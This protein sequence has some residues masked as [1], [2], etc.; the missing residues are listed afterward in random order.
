MNKI[1]NSG[2]EA[3]KIYK[4]LKAHFNQKSY[5]FNKY[6]ANTKKVVESWN[7]LPCKNLFTY[8]GKKLNLVK[9]K[10]L[11]IANL[12]LDKNYFPVNFD[13]EY[14]IY[15]EWLGRI[16]SIRYGFLLDVKK[17]KKFIDNNNLT[18]NNIIRSNDNK[19]PIALHLLFKNAISIESFIILDN[20]FHILDN[21]NNIRTDIL[22]LYEHRIIMIKKY[23]LFFNIKNVE[24]YKKLILEVFKG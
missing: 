15:I 12:L 16:E 8:Y 23:K 13:K 9:L 10:N 24:E 21:C 7:S 17:I 2:F 5:D 1:I 11:F 22:L 3:Y 18:I 4:A 6:K 19:L 14:K 20:I